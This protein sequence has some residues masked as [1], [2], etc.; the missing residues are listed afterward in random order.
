MQVSYKSVYK[1]NNGEIHYLGEGVFEVYPLE[2]EFPISYKVK[3]ENNWKVF[4]NSL[5]KEG[6]VVN[7]ELQ[8]TL[9][10]LMARENKY[11]QQ[12]N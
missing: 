10:E 3:K 2:S 7:E 5:L 1:Y 11:V 6:Y 8:S 4:D 12:I 9:D